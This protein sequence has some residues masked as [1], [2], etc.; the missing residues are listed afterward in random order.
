MGVTKAKEVDENKVMLKTVSKSQQKT[1][2]QKKLEME[3]FLMLEKLLAFVEKLERD[4][5]VAFA[6]INNIEQNAEEQL[7]RME[8]VIC[9]MTIS[10]DQQER[11]SE[12]ANDRVCDLLGGKYAYA[13]KKF[14]RS[15]LSCLWYDFRSKFHCCHSFRDLNP[16][17]FD[18]AVDFIKKWEYIAEE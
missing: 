16:T 11:L 2:E 1:L 12:A 10:A 7:E 6:Q 14:K 9:C 17:L 4:L 8:T 3:T 5:P 15:Y 13:Y 18:K